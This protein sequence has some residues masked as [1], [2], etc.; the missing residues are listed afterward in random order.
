MKHQT[1]FVTLGALL[2]VGAVTTVGATMYTARVLQTQTDA[3][4][5]QLEQLGATVTHD[6]RR[7]SLLGREQTTV[8]T[9][10]QLPDTPVTLTSVVR[11]GP[12]LPGGRFGAALVNTTVTFA[13]DVQRAFER[14]TQGGRITVES[15]VAFGG[16]TTSVARVP[17][18]QF[19]ESDGSLTWSAL[20]GT[21]VTDGDRT[22]SDV[23]S[24]GFAFADATTN[25]TFTKLSATSDTHLDDQLT[26]GRSDAA[27]ERVVVRS[28]GET[29]IG[30]NLQTRWEGSERD[31][32]VTSAMRHSL[33]QLSGGG[34][35]VRDLQLG[36][37]LRSLD[38]AGLQAL[39]KALSGVNRN[40]DLTDA[41]QQDALAAVTTLLRA[42]PVFAVD[43]L[44][45]TTDAGPVTFDGA[46]SL[47][48]PAQLDARDLAEDPTPLLTHLQFD[49]NVEANERALRDLEGVT[50]ED[51]IT[52]LEE[53]GYLRRDG[54]TLR[55]K[56]HFDQT[57]LRVNGRLLPGTNP[58]EAL[59][60]RSK[61][62]EQQT[63][64][65][66]RQLYV[67]QE[68][69][70]ADHDVYTA[71]VGDLDQSMLGTC[72]TLVT[73]DVTF[74]NTI[75]WTANVKSR[76]TSASV[77]IDQDGDVY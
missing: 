26:L 70:W 51:L 2:L 71:R 15:L 65:C 23:R 18:G 30:T 22:R 41:Q 43:K 38:R 35:R 21:F 69:Y 53:E 31:G 17:G 72:L 32:R 5:Q 55:S 34:V 14:A 75:E 29:L 28:D 27:F 60:A 64:A 49:G 20:E 6:T 66:A 77:T 48:N 10:E 1:V 12:A 61:A 45:F 4:T 52:P 3:W 50:G 46:V 44:S 25:V 54:A 13:P 42:G 16:R 47:K 58:G 40:G 68:V 57:G 39:S 59:H 33:A 63:T 24:D 76:A 11:A 37:S 67:A 8:I 7:A 62:Y 56:L 74:A 36:W 73:Y 9:F 19:S